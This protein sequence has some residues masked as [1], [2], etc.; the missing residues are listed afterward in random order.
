VKKPR[1]R[2]A[3]IRHA[4][5]HLDGADLIVLAASLSKAFVWLGEPEWG[6]SMPRFLE[7]ARPALLKAFKCHPL[8]GQGKATKRLTGLVVT[9]SDGSPIPFMPETD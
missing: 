9:K 2:G 3:T 5:E 4:I 7:E 6:Q 1:E 8:N